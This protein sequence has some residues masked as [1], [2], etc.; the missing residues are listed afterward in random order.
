MK[1]KRGS[2][3]VG[4]RSQL[5]RLR[6]RYQEREFHLS[7]GMPDTPLNRS[8]SRRRASEIEQDIH[9][10]QFDS[11]LKKYRPQSH[12]GTLT[13]VQLFEQFTATRE[14]LAS[15]QAI[16]SRY[17]PLLNNLKRF[18]Q[19]ITSETQARSFVDMLR[20]RQSA[21]IANQNLSLLKS[22]GD[23]AIKSEQWET[24]HFANIERLKA[25]RTINPKR[26]PF[27]REET[28]KLLDAARLHPRWHGYHDFVMTLLYLGLRPSEAIGL[29]WQHLNWQ[30]KTITICE[31]L[32][33]SPS[34]RRAKPTKNN[35]TRVIDLHLDLLAMFQGRLSG[36]RPPQELIF[37]TATGQPIDDHNFCQ[38]T[39]KDLCKAAGIP[40]RVPYAARHSLGSHLLENGASIPQVAEILGNNPETTARYYAHAINRPQMPGF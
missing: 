18:G 4:V 5:L 20:S 3:S 33:R 11:T 21:L 22:F 30:Q 17:Y 12:K 10:G 27:T 29:R 8:I 31:S 1:N 7:L 15:P 38:R 37:T 13:T 24:N 40:Y 6:W 14:G 39:W 2:V 28:R 9:L 25:T 19:D 35:K 26:L 23:W 32:S 16:K 34:G 36:G